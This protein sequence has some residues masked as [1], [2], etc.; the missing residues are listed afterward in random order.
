MPSSAPAC[1]R[2]PAEPALSDGVVPEAVEVRCGPEDSGAPAQFLS[3][4]GLW[5]VREAYPDLAPGADLGCWRVLAGQGPGRQHT[6]RLWQDGAD[7]W[8]LLPVRA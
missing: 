8:L 2:R 5:V 1:T 4:S 3:R 7:R 6:F